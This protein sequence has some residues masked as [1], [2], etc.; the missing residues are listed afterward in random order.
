MADLFDDNFGAPATTE[1]AVAVE[2]SEAA[3][4]PAAEFLAQQQDEI[5]GIT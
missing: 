4:D 3:F 1:P 2:S 5:A